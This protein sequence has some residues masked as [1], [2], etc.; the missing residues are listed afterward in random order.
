M[1]TMLA[2]PLLLL[3]VS[4]LAAQPPT[5]PWEGVDRSEQRSYSAIA[6]GGMLAG[7]FLVTAVCDGSEGQK[8]WGVCGRSLAGS[9]FNGALLGGFAGHVTYLLTA[10]REHYAPPGRSVFASAEA[11][12]PPE[13]APCPAP[14]DG[15]RGRY[16]I[17]AAGGGAVL[18]GAII[19]AVC[20]DPDREESRVGEAQERGKCGGNYAATVATGAAAGAFIGVLATYILDSLL[21]GN[22]D[23]AVPLSVDVATFRIPLAIGW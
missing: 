20:G 3:A 15:S 12:C 9:A 6:G 2:T 7:V 4:P 1:K 19:A 23:Y 10:D 22:V 16:V 5:G 11:P 14:T 13:P 8:D 21:E 18:G 17:L